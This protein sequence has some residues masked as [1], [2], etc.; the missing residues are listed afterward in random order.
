MREVMQNNLSVNIIGSGLGGLISGAILAKHG[1]KVNVFEARMKIGGYATS[2]KRKDYLFDSSLHEFNGFYP[3]DTKLCMFRFLDLFEKIKLIKIP[4]PYTSVFNDLQFTVPH[5]YKELKAGLIKEFP[6]DEK[7]INQVLD[8]IERASFD[9]N[10]FMREKNVVLAYIKT[11]FKYKTLSKYIFKNTYEVIWKKIKNPRART[12]IAQLYSYY[13]DDLKKLNFLF[14]ANPTYS[15]FMESYWISG[16]S[17]TLSETMKDIIEENGG[18]VY[19]RKKISKIIFK[20]KKAVGVV[21]NGTE[22]YYSDITI[23]NS[24]LKYTIENLIDKKNIP[25]FARL[26]AIKTIS[27]T[28]LFSIY[29]GMKI[30]I[31][32]LGFT[33][34]CYI[35]NE[36]EDLGDIV[37]NNELI[38]IS[39]RPIFA[40]GY[41]LDDSLTTKGKT[42][43]NICVSDNMKQWDKLRN[44][45]EEYKREKERAANSILKRV[46]AKFPGFIENIEIMEIG[47]PITM[48][49]YSNN[50]DGA[51][52]GACQRNSQSTIFRFPNQIKNRNLYFSSAWVSPG[53]GISGVMMS[54]YK[55]V[56]LILKKY[57][58]LNKLED[59]KKPEYKLNQKLE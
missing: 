15:Y 19:T 32:K 11:L 38:D 5:N 7:G 27:S 56:N 30:D 2:W 23:C 47:T 26:K 4:S 20:N 40:V 55:T 48:E 10:N 42:V 46:E 41:N 50:P 44:N 14:F 39:M 9:S 25:Y 43:V 1:F 18:K 49:K 21:A 16:T 59:F 54:A 53:G 28:S 29:L 52:Y 57:K 6:E 17:S 8:L 58:I 33:E 12:I 35:I 37:S 31:K 36:K 51:V 22:E 3:D 13:S 24:P 34:F 45:K